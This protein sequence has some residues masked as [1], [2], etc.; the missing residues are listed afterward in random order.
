[1]NI[2]ISVPEVLDFIKKMR[3]NTSRPFKM[4]GMNIQEDVGRYLTGLMK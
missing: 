4:T 1:M 3:V 2:E